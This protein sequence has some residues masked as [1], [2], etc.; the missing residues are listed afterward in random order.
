MKFVNE[1]RDVL[2]ELFQ[3][4]PPTRLLANRFKTV[5]ELTAGYLELE[6]ASAE[7]DAKLREQNFD[8][9]CGGW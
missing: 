5:E 2:G 6:Q 8:R 7:L 1:G 3:P 4:Q 9:L